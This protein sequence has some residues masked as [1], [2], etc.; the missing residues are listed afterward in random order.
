M[1]PVLK[2]E[3]KVRTRSW[4]MP[5]TISLYLLLLCGFLGLLA[6]QMILGYRSYRGIRL[7]DLKVLYA[8]ITV[9]QLILIAFII[10]ATTSS[11]ICGEKERR[12]FD[13]L[14]CTRLSSF[15]IVS[16]KLS[17][18]LSFMIILLVVSIPIFSIFFLFGV[19]TPTNVF[20]LFI[21]YLVTALLFGSIGIFS[22]AFFRKTTTSTIFTY[23][24]VLM[25]MFGTG[26]CLIVARTFADRIGIN[27]I[28]DT[29]KAIYNAVVYMNPMVG[30]GAILE[31]Q[32]GEGPIREI[33]IDR[34]ANANLLSPLYYNMGFSFIFS[35]I[36]LFMTSLKINP[37]KKFANKGEDKKNKK[38]ERKEIKRMK[39]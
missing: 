14:L 11:S 17:A 39:R 34:K 24:F 10:P 25:L 33:L 32:F 1:N 35:L 28:S 6:S 26:F 22:S 9:F 2:K 29:I 23:F 18:S 8:T 20:L 38:I 7:E 36:L 15:S 5:I 27:N 19:I 21:Y 12:T 3:L 31:N 30:I 13:L 37:M 16:G 4:K